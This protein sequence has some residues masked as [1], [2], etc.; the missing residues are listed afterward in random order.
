[1]TTLVLDDLSSAQ[2]AQLAA[3][4]VS[5]HCEWRGV[6]GAGF[7]AYFGSLATSTSVPDRRSIHSIG[8]GPVVLSGAVA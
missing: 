7:P 4:P 2:R 6:D 8:L 3:I 5:D 1:M